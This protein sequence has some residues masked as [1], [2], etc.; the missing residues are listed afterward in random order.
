[1]IKSIIN[2][3]YLYKERE[4]F[5][6]KYTLIATNNISAGLQADDIIILKGKFI[7]YQCQYH[8][9]NYSFRSQFPRL[10]TNILG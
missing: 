10:P 2:A 9:V 6:M 1:M 8:V 5:T 4:L 3:M 7:V